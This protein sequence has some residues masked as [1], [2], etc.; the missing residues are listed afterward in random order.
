[1]SKPPYGVKTN[2]YE[3]ALG[4]SKGLVCSALTNTLSQVGAAHEAVNKAE[5]EQTSTVTVKYNV[6]DPRAFSGVECLFYYQS[7]EGSETT[8]VSGMPARKFKGF[9]GLGFRMVGATPISRTKQLGSWITRFEVE[10]SKHYVDGSNA[11]KGTSENGGQFF[12]PLEVGYRFA[13]Q[14]LYGF[15]TEA[16]V[17][18]DLI[19]SW[20]AKS[21]PFLDKINY[22]AN[23]FY[24]IPLHKFD[25][26]LEFGY[27]RENGVSMGESEHL[28]QQD[29]WQGRLRVGYAF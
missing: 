6:Y 18:L 19:S 25:L 15:G 5:R 10:F 17:G 12:M 2:G 24:R 11:N 7:G 1:M 28:V 23:V 22:G 9:L 14:Y 21:N 26:G 27:R 29:D 8:G 3:L 4:D 16:H 13:P 20:A